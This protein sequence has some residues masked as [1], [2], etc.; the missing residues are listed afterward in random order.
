LYTTPYLVAD[1]KRIRLEWLGP[2]LR[3]DEKGWLKRAEVSQRVEEKLGRL[4]RRWLTDVVGS[5]SRFMKMHYDITG[6]LKTCGA[7]FCTL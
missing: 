1:L 7:S 3:M 6:R 5:Y 4:R 2:V